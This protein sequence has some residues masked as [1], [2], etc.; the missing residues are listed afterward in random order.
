MCK[1]PESRS[2]ELN[3]NTFTP[4]YAHPRMGEDLIESIAARLESFGD[5]L[6]LERAGVKL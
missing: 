3:P 2:F 4:V 1:E 6:R 5:G